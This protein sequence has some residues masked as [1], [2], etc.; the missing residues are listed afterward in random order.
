MPKKKKAFI[1][2]NASQS[3]A[4]VNRSRRDPLAQDSS[5]PQHVLQPTFTG[6][7]RKARDRERYS[8]ATAPAR[9]G[10]DPEQDLGELDGDLAALDLQRPKPT[11]YDKTEFELATYKL[12][13]DGYDYTKHLKEI[14]GG[15][16]IGYATEE[17]ARAAAAEAEAKLKEQ[18]RR[19]ANPG[20]V[21]LKEKT[22]AVLP[23]EALPSDLYHPHLTD[24]GE[25]LIHVDEEVWKAM[26]DAEN[27]DGEWG[28]WEELEDDI[29]DRMQSGK[30]G[31]FA[32]EPDDFSF[33]VD[34]HKKVATWSGEPEPEPRG[35]QFD[36]ITDDEEEFVEVT[37]DE[38][39]EEEKTEEDMIDEIFSWA[40]NDGDDVLN[41]EEFCA[42]QETC[43]NESPSTEQWALMLGALGC[44]PAVGLGR[45]ALGVLYEG[46]GPWEDYE[47]LG[48]GPSDG[49]DDGPMPPE[50]LA[51][52][53]GKGG[54]GALYNTASDASDAGSGGTAAKTTLDEQ[55]EN[56]A[57]EYDDDDI[58][59]LSQHDSRNTGTQDLAKFGSVLDEFELYDAEAAKFAEKKANE[60]SARE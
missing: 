19:R 53:A 33:E 43:G 20:V 16:F 9:I 44:D 45:K 51:L 55:F 38:D 57:A 22:P 11:W 17:Q 31:I 46:E 23:T 37:S 40:D 50:L 48:L 59:G 7:Q 42:L 32:P 58:G 26:E 52:L 3:F 6:N 54:L 25:G 36:D 30:G 4:V 49:E 39:E 5:A 10:R 1:D 29:V 8:A 12:P 28:E 15:Q 56:L 2:K 47:A 24:V 35:G 27:E 60:E 21:E 14:G 13:A 41:L 34:P 18:A